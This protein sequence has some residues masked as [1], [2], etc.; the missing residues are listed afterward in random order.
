MRV[1]RTF[2][3]STLGIL[4]GVVAMSTTA[5]AATDTLVKIE[6]RSGVTQP[7]VVIEPKTKPIASVILFAGGSGK[8]R[9]HR[10][11]AGIRNKNFLVRTR[12][13]F[14]G[15][16]LLVAVVDVPSDRRRVGLIRFRTTLDHARDIKGV[17]DWLR[18]KAD[19]PVFLI[20]ASRGTISAAGV[21]ARLDSEGVG[22]VVLTATVTRYNNAGNKDRV[23]DADLSRI[24]A[25]VL[26]VWHEDDGCYVTPPYDSGRLMSALVNAPVKN[27]LTYKGG[28]EAISNECGSRSEHGFFGIE[29]L[30]VADIAAWIKAQAV[31]RGS[32]SRR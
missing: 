7:F 29:D 8:I 6:T 9:T 10:D 20:G 30:V 2:A 32:Q 11:G 5:M 12:Q 25:P 17:I 31:K 13:L 18:T 1:I 4:L 21:T 3:L 15:H 19:V 23:F 28:K 16:G 24:R 14:A 22:G 26:V 27:L